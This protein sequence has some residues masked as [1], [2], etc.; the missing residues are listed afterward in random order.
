[1]IVLSQLYL[2]WSKMFS[3][4]VAN[5]LR[6][7]LEKRANV[8]VLLFRIKFPMHF[9]QQIGNIFF[10]QKIFFP[11]L[12]LKDITYAFNNLTYISEG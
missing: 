8:F 6:L 11:S 10:Q 3:G 2:L 1:M 5:E 4:T 9:Y 7:L 12:M